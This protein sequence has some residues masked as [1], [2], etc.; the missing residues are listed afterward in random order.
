VTDA[1][2]PALFD[3]KPIIVTVNEVNQA[4][5]LGGVPATASVVEGVA[6]TFT[7]TASDAD[8]PANTLNFSLEGAP[9]GASIDAKTGVFNWTPTAAQGPGTFTFKVKAS[10]NGTPALFDEK[11]IA[12]TVNDGN[13]A[14]VLAAIGAQSVIEGRTLTLSALATDTDA[15]Q[16]LTYTLAPG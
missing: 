7:A 16:T 9:P 11:P 13:H 5:V 15:G 6:Y 14:P 2:T 8:L 10:D 12:I 1:G 4:P 3:E